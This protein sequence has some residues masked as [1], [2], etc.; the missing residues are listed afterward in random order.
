MTPSYSSGCASA[1]YFAASADFRRCVSQTPR[2]C[3]TFD[4]SI[5][6]SDEKRWL[7][8]EPPFVIQSSQGVFDRSPVEKAGAGVIS[9][10]DAIAGVWM[11]VF[12]FCFELWPIT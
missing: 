11:T 6:S 10:R 4:V 7:K 9:E 8:V 5:S 2:S 12:V 1:E 3:E